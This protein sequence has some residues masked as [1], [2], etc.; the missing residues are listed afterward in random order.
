MP[1]LSA[2]AAAQI[3]CRAAASH[4]S[5][6]FRTFQS[7]PDSSAA[8]RRLS[9]GDDHLRITHGGALRCLHRNNQSLIK[10]LSRWDHLRSGGLR[11]AFIT[12]HQPSPQR[13]GRAQGRRLELLRFV[14]WVDDGGGRPQ[15]QRAAV[16]ERDE[17]APLVG[18]P[19]GAAVAVDELLADRIK[20]NG[21]KPLGT[22]VQLTLI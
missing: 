11:E 21:T 22:N 1:T 3:C 5:D 15:P 17:R 10:S 7:N 18:A 20:V 4:G 13:S 19:L 14:S 8:Q 16:V 6:V 2:A 12:G 9:H